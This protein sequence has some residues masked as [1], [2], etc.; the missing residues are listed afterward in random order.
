[1][2]GTNSSQKEQCRSGTAAQGA[3]GSPSLEV[4]RKHGDVALRDVGS[5][6]APLIP[7]ALLILSLADIRSLPGLKT[8]RSRNGGAQIGQG[9]MQI[10]KC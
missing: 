9:S 3:V 1:M 8:N 10:S 7:L 5:G 6:P 2:L 4:F